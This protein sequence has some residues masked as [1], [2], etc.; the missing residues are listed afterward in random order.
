MQGVCTAPVL[1]VQSCWCNDYHFIEVTRFA[2]RNHP[3]S[4]QD[5]SQHV[6]EDFHKLQSERER[7]YMLRKEK[8]F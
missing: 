3:L 8:K 4:M 2:T 1:V 5:N 6:E 7:D